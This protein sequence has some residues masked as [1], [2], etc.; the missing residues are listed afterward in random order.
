M[1]RLAVFL[2]LIGCIVYKHNI[3]KQNYVSYRFLQNF[4]GKFVMLF[5]TQLDSIHI[6]Y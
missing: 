4:I 3:Q 1:L 6:F 5:Y 2:A